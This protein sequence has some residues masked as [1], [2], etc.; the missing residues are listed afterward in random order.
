MLC[1]SDIMEILYLLDYNGKND[2]KN[3]H[4]KPIR[5]INIDYLVLKIFITNQVSFICIES[6]G[7]YLC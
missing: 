7:K 5:S 1:V 6:T 2:I 4:L 3:S